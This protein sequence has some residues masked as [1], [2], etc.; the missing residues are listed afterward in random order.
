ML[1]N[2]FGFGGNNAAVVMS[3]PDPDRAAPAVAAGDDLTLEIMVAD[4]L[5]AAGH[6]EQTLAALDAGEAAT[7]LIPA[8]TLKEGLPPRLI[9][10][11][12]R[13]PR[14]ALA[15]ARALL[16]TGEEELVPGS[17]FFGT[18]WGP[19]SETHDFLV[20]LFASDEDLSSPTDFVGS[21]HNA[22]AGQLA[23]RY[24]ARGINLTATG[25][26]SSFEQALFMAGLTAT[27]ADEPLLL[28]GADEHHARLSSLLD[29]AAGAREAEGGGAMLL[30][31]PREGGLHIR[32]IRLGLDAGTMEGIP[33]PTL[34]L[35][36]ATGEQLQA[37]L[38]ATGHQG[39]VRHTG[40]TL[41]PHASASAQAA[42]LG[43]LMVQQG[44]V[45]SVLLFT[46]GDLPA[47]T[48]IWRR[49]AA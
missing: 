36:G 34:A 26:A 6:A 16:E 35:S 13:L 8:A 19:L 42:A 31:R 9:R 25:G 28:L 1:S 41:G 24:K 14:L 44:R 39:E 37:L 21:V 3:R 5:S 18:G 22:P 29:P 40:P 45:S 2:S 17:I 23:M 27:P 46:G 48:A 7:G 32:P 43:A 10:R 38:Q 11:L 15:L 49:G 47:A 12:K 33:T 20:E 4:C 30:R